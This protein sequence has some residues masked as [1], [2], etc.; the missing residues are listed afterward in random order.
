MAGIG[1]VATKKPIIG[2][3]AGVVTVIPDYTFK[4]FADYDTMTKGN[5]ICNSMDKRKHK[6]VQWRPEPSIYN[7]DSAGDI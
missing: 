6:E 1:I 4:P 2:F 7:G 3:A 5:C